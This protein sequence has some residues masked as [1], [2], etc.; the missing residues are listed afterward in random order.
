MSDESLRLLVDERDIVRVALRYCR[1]L[2]TRD[3]GLLA[4]VFLDDATAELGDSGLLEGIDAIT[5]TCRAA[6]SPLDA[7]HHMVSNHEVAVEGDAASHRCYVQAQHVRRGVVGGRNL[8]IAG[9][10]EDRLAR[11]SGGWRITHRSLIVTWTEG[12]SAVVAPHA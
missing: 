10:Y 9:H 4:E 1:A 2:D 12:N 11:A 3:W 5:A 6:L 7:S 8:I